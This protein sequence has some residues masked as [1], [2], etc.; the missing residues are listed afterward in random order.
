MKYFQLIYG[1]SIHPAPGG[2]VV[3]KEEFSE[4]V[5]AQQILEK[6]QEE[7][8]QYRLDVAKECEAL[9]EEAEKAGFEAGMA[10][11]AEQVALLEQEIARKEE[12]MEAL[13][14]PLALEAAKKIVGREM[15]VDAGTVADIV[16]TN[17][18]AVTGHR[19]IT[20]YCSKEDRDV[21]EERKDSLK[22][23]FEQLESFSIQERDDIESGGCV[24]ETEAG[25]INAQ[26]D[27]QWRALEAAF[28]VLFQ[29]KNMS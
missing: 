29:K 25:I 1:N 28:Q 9:K 22:E 27:L 4:L 17:L 6:V 23:L 13:V 18:R 12:Q 3:P 8:E 26:L 10:Q 15:S 11:W 2:K 5:T 21:L 14:V 20:I 24:I 7:A 16:K 19:K